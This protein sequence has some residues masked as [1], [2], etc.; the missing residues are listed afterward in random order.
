M[1]T[2]L[3]RISFV[4][5]AS[6]SVVSAGENWPRFRGPDA[7]GVA[8]D[9]H[10][11]DRWSETE[12]VAWKADI[13]GRGW[14]SPIVWG[15]RVFL[16]TAVGNVP[17]AKKGL[18]FGG[19]RRAPPEGEQSWRV[20]CLDLNDGKVLWEKT[21]H[22]GKPPLPLHIKN[23]Y[24]SETPVT[25]GERLCVM[26][27]NLGLY[28][29]D[30]D[31]QPLWSTPIEPRK[32]RLAW[33]PASSPV[34]FDDRLI[35]VNDNQEESYLAAINTH[36][37]KEEWRLSREEGT[38]WSTPYVWRNAQRAE[39][40]TAGTNG[41]RSYDAA[42]ELL[43]E[44]EG[45]SSITIGAPYSADGLLFVSSGYVMDRNRPLYAIRPG[46]QGD[47]TLPDDEDQSEFIA[48]RL[49]NEAPYNP[50]TLVYRGRVY[51]LYDKGLL[52][53]FDATTGAAIYGGGN[54]KKRIPNG[55]AFT[56]SPWA[57]DGKVF[58]L[59]EDG[60]TFVFAAGDEFKLLHTNRLGDDETSLAT[61]A[62]VGDRLL[63]R[64][65]G[66][67]YCIGR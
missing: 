25:D 67:L 20:L 9:A 21:A 54:G 59:N 30:L 38:N 56:A 18:Y 6:A 66:R 16:T 57:S 26:F 60:E 51:V 52:A 33:G 22:Q 63:I 24:A 53:C 40:V 35:Y 31:G 15:R 13:P 62:I 47:I 28:C 2:H 49:R 7:T 36:T 37:G 46:A 23:S 1:A 61:P 48:W 17:A 14:S 50:S 32:T 58:C 4:C 8:D 19:E 34:L 64:T 5:F 55:R 39:L 45:M 42:G 44:L 11:P 12:N 27:G 65:E 29:Y 43:W 3:L 10:F 41:V